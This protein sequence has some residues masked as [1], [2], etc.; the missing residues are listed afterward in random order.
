MFDFLERIELGRLM[1]YIFFTGSTL[2]PGTLIIYL[3]SETA[4]WE[5]ELLRICIL[6]MALTI[7]FYIFNLVGATSIGYVFKGEEKEKVDPENNNIFQV[8][9]YIS[10]ASTMGVLYSGILISFLFDFTI[11]NFFITCFF[12]QIAVILIF[13][14]ITILFKPKK[15]KD[16]D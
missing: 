8:C 15:F 5:M 2:L 6:S 12:L 4:F 13:S 9:S 7:P 10:T 3:Y 14:T 11:R 1:F 16:K